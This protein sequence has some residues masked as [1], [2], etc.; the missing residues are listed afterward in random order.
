MKT[1]QR[2]FLLAFSAYFIFFSL[3]VIGSACREKTLVS[4]PFDE[5]LCFMVQVPLV[6]RIALGGVGFIS[7]FLGLFSFFLAI[8]DHR[9]YSR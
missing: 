6:L 2:V 9:I 7:I 8:N 4:S 5:A 1:W 3:W